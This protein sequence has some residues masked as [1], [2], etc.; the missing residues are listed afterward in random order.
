[1]ITLRTLPFNGELK[2][3]MEHCLK[4]GNALSRRALEKNHFESG[5][6]FAALPQNFD[7]SQLPRYDHGGIAS[8]KILRP[9]LLKVESEEYVQHLV[10]EIKSHLQDAS[11]SIIFEDSLRSPND[12]FVRN[13]PERLNIMINNA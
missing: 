11:K 10:S 1:M 6:V 13:N 3:Y 2:K 9:G 4:G 12:P 5:F 8:L 7:L